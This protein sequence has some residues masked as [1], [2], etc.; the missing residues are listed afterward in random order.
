MSLRCLYFAAFC[1]SLLGSLASNTSAAEVSID[2]DCEWITVS[3]EIDRETPTLLQRTQDNCWK[4]IKRAKVNRAWWNLDSPGGDLD[5]AM[6]VGRIIRE[7]EGIVTVYN[8]AQCVSAC[9]FVLLG[10]VDRFVFGTIGLHRPYSTDMPSTA[11]E[12]GKE[13]RGMRAK[14]QSYLREMNI[15]DRLLDAMNAVGPQ[16]IRW[17]SGE[18]DSKELEDLWITGRDP[19]WED[20]RL[21]ERA[22]ELNISKKELIRRG[23]LAQECNVWS[24]KETIHMYLQC[25]KAIV[26]IGISKQEFLKRYQ[27]AETQCDVFR[28]KGDRHGRYQCENTI[29]REGHYP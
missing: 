18:K 19:V 20:L 24:T 5:A 13:Y 21:S 16:Q 27:L 15:P 1:G 22:K 26:E 2:E 8:H 25:Q 3:G 29:L 14:L 7:Q 12:A 10:G 9:V 28:K 17:L 11:D 6:Q 23:Q 4:K